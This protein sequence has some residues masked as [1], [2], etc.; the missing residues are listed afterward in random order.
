MRCG[1]NSHTC[2]LVCVARRVAVAAHRSDLLE[3]AMTAPGADSTNGTACAVVLPPR[4]AMNATT[5]SSHDAYTAAPGRPPGRSSRPSASPASAGS[6]ARRSEPVRD[7]RRPTA[8]RTTGSRVSARI[9]GL[10]ASAATGSPGAGHSRTITRAPIVARTTTH[11]ARTKTVTVT[12]TVGVCGHACPV[13]P[14]RTSPANFMP[15]DSAVPPVIHAASLAANQI[16][17]TSATRDQH[18]TSTAHPATVPPGAADGRGP[19]AR[20]TTSSRRG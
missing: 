19:S 14:C 5:V 10:R 12:T 2:P 16:S 6:T 11:P 9:R 17:P 7:R 13:R 15:N 8:T 20:L 18:A 4:G 1:S 3:V